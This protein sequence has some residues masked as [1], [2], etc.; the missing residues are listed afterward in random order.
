MDSI[1]H[2]PDGQDRVKLLKVKFEGI[3]IPE[4]FQEIKLLF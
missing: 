1:L 4:V 3:Q 2:L